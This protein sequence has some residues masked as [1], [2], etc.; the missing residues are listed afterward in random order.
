MQGREEG[1]EEGLRNGLLA[2]IELALELRFG[3]QGLQILPEIAQL[4]DLAVIQAL[5][6][7]LK[8]ANT[9]DELRQVYTNPAP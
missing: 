5:Y 9:L 8:T 6:E 7:R 1:R 2:G 4:T 3:Q